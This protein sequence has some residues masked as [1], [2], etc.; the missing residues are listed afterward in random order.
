MESLILTLLFVFTPQKNVKPDPRLIQLRDEYVKASNEYKDSLKK[1]LPFYESDLKRAEQRLESSKRLLA[2]GLVP[3]SQVEENE[4]AI[5]FAKEKIAETNRQI[6][7]VDK[8]IADAQDDTKLVTEYKK[9][10][11]ER[12]KAKRS[13]CSSWTLTARQRTTSRSVS[14][15]YMFVCQN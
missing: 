5:S 9:A 3:S 11:H 4:R 13:P 6:N 2:E 15:S 10:V 8:I 7:E 14:F 1:L 12:R